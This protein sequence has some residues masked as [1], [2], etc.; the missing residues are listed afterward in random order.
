M[1]EELDIELLTC[2]N[3]DVEDESRITGSL[4]VDLRCGKQVTSV[5]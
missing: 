1:V 5:T 3:E 4:T 2:E